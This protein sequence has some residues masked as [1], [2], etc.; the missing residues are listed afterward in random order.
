MS[1]AAKPITVTL[2]G[3]VTRTTAEL[4]DPAQDGRGATVR[5]VD[6]TTLRFTWNGRRRVLTDTRTRE[7][8]THTEQG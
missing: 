7:T 3:A 5:I 1:R 8:E 4:T 6:E 2:R